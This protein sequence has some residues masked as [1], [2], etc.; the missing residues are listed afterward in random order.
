MDLFFAKITG[1]SGQGR[2]PSE[3]RYSLEGKSPI[4]GDQ[5]TLADIA[6]PIPLFEMIGGAELAVDPQPVGT[7]MMIGV[8]DDGGFLAWPQLT[9][10]AEGC[11]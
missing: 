3:H 11:A 6:I 9:L 10:P 8:D 1:N 2:P 5:V 4:T 7:W